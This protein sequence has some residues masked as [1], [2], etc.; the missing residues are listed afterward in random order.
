MWILA[1]IGSI[2]L[3]YLILFLSIV[4]IF[5]PPEDPYGK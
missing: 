4:A 3:I 1:I 5:L 2:I